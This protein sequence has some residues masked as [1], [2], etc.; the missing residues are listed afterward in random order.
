MFTHR[1]RIELNPNSFTELSRKIQSEIMPLLRLQKGFCDGL[2]TVAPERATATGDS[3]WETKA[4]A[5]EYQRNGFPKILKILSSVA[6]TPPTA[7][8]FELQQ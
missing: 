6:K 8:I 7:T 4:D 1:V 3:R 2:T 5:E